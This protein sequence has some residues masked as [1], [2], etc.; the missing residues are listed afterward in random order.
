M[1]C[2]TPI[3]AYAKGAIPEIIDD[4]VTGFI[5]N[6]SDDD[7]RGEWIVKKTGVDGLCEAIEKIYSMPEGEYQK[8]RQNCR[9]HVEKN[10]TARR[11][12]EEYLKIYKE[13]VSKQNSYQ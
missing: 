6:S 12:V 8:M 5:V 13:V 10:F 1:S 2:G 11:M 7:I 4:G 3:I 9:T